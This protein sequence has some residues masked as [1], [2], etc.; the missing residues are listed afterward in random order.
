MF[1]VYYR[2]TKFPHGSLVIAIKPKAKYR[3]RAAAMLLPYIKEKHG[4]TKMA[5]FTKI[6]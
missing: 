5:Y 4:V 2:H 1:T 3:F 6:F